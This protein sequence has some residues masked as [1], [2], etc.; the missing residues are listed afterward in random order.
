MKAKV[1]KGKAQSEAIGVDASIRSA[2][3]TLSVARRVA[4]GPTTVEIDRALERLRAALSH[5]AV[6]P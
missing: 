2:M 4:N 5:S 6:E 3:W 1:T